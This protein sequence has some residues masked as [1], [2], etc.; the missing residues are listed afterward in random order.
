[1]KKNEDPL[2]LVTKLNELS[3]ISRTQIKSADLSEDLK[4][5]NDDLSE[6]QK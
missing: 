5:E 2:N 4:E 1:M 3:K 6:E